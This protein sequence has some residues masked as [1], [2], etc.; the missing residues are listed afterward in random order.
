MNKKLV[1]IVIA[2]LLLG[3]LGGA[4]IATNKGK[5]LNVIKQNID[6]MIGD[7]TSNASI[8]VSQSF[9]NDTYYALKKDGSVWA[10][11]SNKYGLIGNGSKTETETD[12][13]TRV[14]G[15]PKIKSI[16]AGHGVCIALDKEG[17]IWT[18]GQASLGNSDYDG[19]L[20]PI[21]IE[22]IKNVAFITPGW[23]TCTAL[24]TDGSVWAWGDN[25]C[26]SLGVYEID[27]R[28]PVKIQGLPSMK[29][30]SWIPSATNPSSGYGIGIAKDNSVWQWGNYPQYASGLYEPIKVNGLKNVVAVSG[31]YPNMALKT[32]G[33]VSLWEYCIPYG[34]SKFILG[35]LPVKGL[36]D[37]V[38][39][40]SY[41]RDLFAIDN[42][43]IVWDLDCCYGN[44]SDSDA[45]N[46]AKNE[47]LSDVGNFICGRD[48]SI[49]LKRDG[50]VWEWYDYGQIG[51][52]WASQ[53][54]D[55]SGQGFD[56]E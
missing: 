29:S 52:G 18:W 45:V 46:Y 53:V 31:G 2:A 16:Y 55:S 19:S 13:P 41:K 21:K 54:K 30:I 32:D 15:L 23:F 17:N 20:I 56:L 40:Y 5:T 36:K 3:G 7:E 37:I 22:S 6:T 4:F 42:K 34:C 38:S 39:I 48:H 24:K 28:S 11:G 33:T 43:G 47:G 35:E 12:F 8:A 25:G 51:N 50:T 14:E 10:W 1:I 27:L 44:Y 9:F 49:A 26:H